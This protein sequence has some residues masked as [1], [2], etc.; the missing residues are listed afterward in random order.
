MTIAILDDEIHIVK[1][2]EALIPWEELNFEYAGNAQN[3][4]AGLELIM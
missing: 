3:G 4:I 1:L 2:L